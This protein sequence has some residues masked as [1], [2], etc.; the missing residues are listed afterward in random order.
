MAFDA[1]ALRYVSSANG[2]YLQAG[3]FFIPPVVTENGVTLA[4]TTLAAG[5][6]SDGTLAIITFE[7]VAV[8]ASTLILSDVILSDSGGKSSQPQVK[9]GVIELPELVRD[10]N[11]DGVVNIHDLVLVGSN[12][13]QT[14]IRTAQMSTKMAWSILLT[15]CWLRMRY[16]TCQLHLPHVSMPWATLNTVADV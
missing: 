1:S 13:G 10:I 15:W 2:A 9:N 5:S 11:N 16:A 6:N 4:S 12:F 3:A 7:V 8:K 14:G